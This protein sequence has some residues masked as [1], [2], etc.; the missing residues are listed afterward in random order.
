MYRT[1]ASAVMIGLIAA[2]GVGCDEP[3]GEEPAGEEIVEDQ[4]ESE[5]Q[6]DE[7]K[8]PRAVETEM[9][10]DSEIGELPEGVGLEV[11]EAA[12]EVS[13]TD[14][15]GETV[16][17][18]GLADEG[19]SLLVFFYR[20]GWCPF[21]NF[22]VR[23]MTEAYDRFDDRDVVPVAISVDK[24]ERGAE[25]EQAYEI[26]YPV[27]TDPDL[28]VH[29]AFDV[30]YEAG[31]Q[32][33]EKLREG[34]MDIEEASGREHNIYA[35]PSVFVID[36]EG[37]VRWAHANRDYQVRPSPEQLVGVIDGLE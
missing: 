12:P 30:T 1:M 31:E 11:G 19:E 27:L 29:E 21:C 33:V 26:P 2:L 8:A 14:T 6:A 25:T 34:G 37:T 28:T 13:T 17:L 5:D 24:P 15:D 9:P 18:L 16:E 32:E 22:Q 23:E 7:P 10:E 20:G 3:E 35:I 4:A 36:A